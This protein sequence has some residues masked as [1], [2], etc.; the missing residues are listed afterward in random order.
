MTVANPQTLP[1]ACPLLLITLSACSFP[2]PLGPEQSGS[3]QVNQQR[4]LLLS[5][6][7]LEAELSSQLRPLG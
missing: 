3:K 1:C 6:H 4:H 2:H 5:T 7:S